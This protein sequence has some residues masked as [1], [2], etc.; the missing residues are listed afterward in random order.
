VNSCVT[1]VVAQRF[2]VPIDLSL[3]TEDGGQSWY[4]A[5]EIPVARSMRAPPM[6]FRPGTPFWCPT[7]RISGSGHRNPEF[8]PKQTTKLYIG[9]SCLVVQVVVVVVDYYHYYYSLYGT[10]AIQTNSRCGRSGLFLLH[11]L[12]AINNKSQQKSAA[13]C[14]T[15]TSRRRNAPLEATH[16]RQNS[17]V[18]SLPP[19]K[20]S[21]R[22]HPPR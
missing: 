16:H 21:P 20:R 3:T 7:T 9:L 1:A 19:P 17:R 11:L 12:I 10:A 15:V 6:S 5:T 2:T 22:S 18:Q 4:N 14:C 8:R 13:H